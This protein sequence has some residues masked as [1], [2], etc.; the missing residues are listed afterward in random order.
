MLQFKDIKQ[1]YPVFILNKQELTVTQGKVTA[2]AFPRLDLNPQKAATSPTQ[3]VVDIT[4]EAN[5]K[6]ATYTIPEQ[7][8][9]T[10][11]GDIVLSTESTGLVSEIE[12][13]KA[14][15][16]QAL[17]NVNR[18]K[19]V[20]AK[21]SDLLASLNPAFKQKQETEK[22]FGQIESSIGEIKDILKAQ[23]EAM[24]NFIKEFKS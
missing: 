2:A 21:A 3:M 6:T 5:G 22:R 10:Y 15:A 20:L 11:A 17:A 13:M 4:I 19:E 14:S 7:L 18:H 16:E 1:N 23:Q 8:S 9:V 12:A 24:A